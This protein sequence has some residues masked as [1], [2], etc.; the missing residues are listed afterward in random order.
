MATHKTAISWTTWPPP[1]R[2]AEAESGLSA[3]SLTLGGYIF[4]TGQVVLVGP[5][6]WEASDRE[7]AK[8][9]HEKG[10][11]PCATPAPASDPNA[12]PIVRSYSSLRACPRPGPPAVHRAFRFVDENFT[13]MHAEKGTLSMA[14]SGPNS[15]SSQFFVAFDEQ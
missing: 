12:R 1:E 9:G 13:H 5:A 2:A 11:K 10:A 3:C 8:R 7:G 4:D 15:N 14:N 6:G